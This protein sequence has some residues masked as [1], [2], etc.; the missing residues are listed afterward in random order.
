M[1]KPKQIDLSKDLV[2]TGGKIMSVLSVNNVTVESHAN[3]HLPNG[4]DPLTT[5]SAVTLSLSTTNSTG[6]ANSFARSDHTHEITGVQPLNDQLSALAVFDTNGILVRNNTN[7]FVGRSLTG[8]TNTISIVNGSG[9]F[10]NPTITIADN[11]II[12]G[13]ESIKIPL[14]TT[15]QRPASPSVGMIRFN[16]TTNK[17]EYYQN[18]NWILL[19]DTIV[20]SIIA[21]TGLS[22]GTI[23]SSGTIALTNTGVTAGTY[24]R[25]TVD[26]QGRVTTGTKEMIYIS[27]TDP[28]GS[29]SVDDG[30]I[31]YKI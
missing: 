16:S 8:T 31:W 2:F 3:R 18:S 27:A 29:G 9:V 28:A 5:N 23:N 22:G 24:G 4:S 21:G 13:T 19:P 26:A 12:P 11:P 25:V 7:S 20:S 17:F 30:S 6:T 10:G 14:G 1:I 15:A